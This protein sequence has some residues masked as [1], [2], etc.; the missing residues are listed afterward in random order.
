VQEAKQAMT[1]ALQMLEQVR[2]EA[3]IDRDLKIKMNSLHFDDYV[4]SPTFTIK[5]WDVEKE[6]F[7]TTIDERNNF[8]R[9]QGFFNFLP[10]TGENA[11]QTRIY[12]NAAAI[13]QMGKDISKRV[14][15][16]NLYKTE[17]VE[18]QLVEILR[19]AS[20]ALEIVDVNL[21]WRA[22]LKDIGDFV[23][24]DVK[25]GSA[26]FNNVPAMI[27]EIGYDPQGIKIPVKLWSMMMVPF[28]G[29]EPGFSGTVGGYN[30]TI[31]AE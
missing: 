22:L 26:I 23:Y 30:A 18:T 19:L 29:Y 25:I 9:A 2:L 27:R 3:F 28:S 6:S 17:D 8:N 13:T 4:A 11:Y 7:K 5:N 14:E 31:V 10:S 24:I 15:F 21:T 20:S 16:P 1:Y 12:K